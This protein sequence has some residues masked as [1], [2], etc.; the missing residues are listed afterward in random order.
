MHQ[1]SGHVDENLDRD[2]D[3]QPVPRL[4]PRV[5]LEVLQRPGLIAQGSQHVA[6]RALEVK[7]A[8]V[9][10]GVVGISRSRAGG[11]RTG[12]AA[13]FTLYHAA[14]LLGITGRWVAVGLPCGSI[15]QAQQ[16]ALLAMPEALAALPI[17]PTM[18]AAAARRWHTAAPAQDEP[19]VTL[20]PFLALLRA[21]EREG[22]AG[23]G[24]WA[25]SAAQ[26]VVAVGWTGRL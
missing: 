19:V 23:A 17:A 24:S 25:G 21:Q 13:V 9:K 22:Q 20:A 16:L 4:V 7:G 10:R 8:S 3:R 5:H 2:G 11:V 26:L 12:V 1:V 18:E 14:G 15:A 6:A